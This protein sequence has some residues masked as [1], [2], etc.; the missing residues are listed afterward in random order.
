M[1]QKQTSHKY[2][3]Q[4]SGYQREVGG[5][6]AKWIKGLSSTLMDGNQTYDGD[7]SVVYTD[8]EVQCYTRLT[9]K[10]EDNIERLNLAYYNMKSHWFFAD[11]IKTKINLKI[12]P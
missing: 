7:H 6:W 2:R 1:K 12:L 11:I 8:S 4:I 3:E 10:R 9:M 5:D